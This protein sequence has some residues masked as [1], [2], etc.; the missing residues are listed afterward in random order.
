MT[1]PPSNPNSK[2]SWGVVRVAVA[3]IAAGLLLGI[4]SLVVERAAF[5]AI[6]DMKPPP[7]LRL[8]ASSAFERF[9][10][11]LSFHVASSPRLNIAPDE[12]RLLDSSILSREFPNVVFFT[13]GADGIVASMPVDGGKNYFFAD[14]RIKLRDA[15][16]FIGGSG[17][18]LRSSEDANRI[19]SVVSE[20]VGQAKRPAVHQRVTENLWRIGI[21][22][23][24][25][26]VTFLEVFTDDSGLILSGGLF[27]LPTVLYRGGR[28]IPIRD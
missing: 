8:D 3:G 16:A 13:I 26:N 19:V 7:N 22:E 9:S 14:P 2:S 20:L 5:T 18:S 25:S 15:I 11:E 24:E 27:V 23:F 12:V 6:R 10:Q 1:S 28:Q 21:E 17:M 4:S